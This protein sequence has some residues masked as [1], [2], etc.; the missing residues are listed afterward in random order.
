VSASDDTELMRDLIRLG[1]DINRT[2]K[3][4]RRVQAIFDA[5]LLLLAIA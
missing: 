4:S 2:N 1:A 5:I 3:V